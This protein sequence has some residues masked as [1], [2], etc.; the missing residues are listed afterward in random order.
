MESLNKIHGGSLLRLSPQQLVD[1]ASTPET[2]NMGCDG[3]HPVWTF[4]W[5]KANSIAEWADYPY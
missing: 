4:G 5:L 3:G 1:C 2:G